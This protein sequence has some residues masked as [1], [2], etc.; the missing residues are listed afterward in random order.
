MVRAFQAFAKER[1]LRKVTGDIEIKSA[2]DYTPKPRRPGLREKKRCSVAK[3][4]RG[5]RW[6]GCY[7][8][9]YG[10]EKRAA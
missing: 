2:A 9:Q 7:L 4:I 8:G 1:Q 3:E 6:K 10:N 5:G